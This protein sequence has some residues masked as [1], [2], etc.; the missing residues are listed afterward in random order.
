M[1]GGTAS[2]VGGWYYNVCWGD[3]QLAGAFTISI[4]DAV[5]NAI[6]TGVTS[7]AANAPI[8][9]PVGNIIVFTALVAVVVY[10]Y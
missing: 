5:G 3:I 8:T 4:Y 10:A 2:P 6:A 1:F 9:I 7:V